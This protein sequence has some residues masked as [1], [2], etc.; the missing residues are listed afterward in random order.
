M[1]KRFENKKIV[2]GMATI[3]LIFAIIIVSSF[4]P[5]ILDPK[6]IMTEE[7]LTDELI[8]SAIVLSV[9]IA[10]LTIAQAANA[11]NPNSEIAKSKVEFKGSLD[12]IPNHSILFQWIKRVLQ[13]RDKKEIAEREMAKLLIPL[14]IYNLEEADILTL[15]TPQ[16]INGKY[17][18]PYDIERLRAVIK[19]KKKIGKI[20]FV[21]PNYYTSVKSIDSDK[22][23][24]ELAKSENIKKIMSIIIDLSTRIIMT[25][26]FASILGSLVRDLTQDGGNTAQAWMR[27]LSRMFAFGQSC[28]LGYT[29]GCKLNDL[30][31]FYILKRVEIHT[32]FLEDKNFIYIDESK[33]LYLLEHKEEEYDQRKE[34]IYN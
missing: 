31:A 19:L 18:G 3:G 27:F 1:K 16:S 4:W 33:E 6:R 13:P 12:K 34:D 23:L 7:F 25:W 5:F 32:L 22:T 24:S 10:A 30:D 14:E 9:T 21:S 26:V 11:Q 20:R 28:F 15:T 8:I 2:F 29:M 17:Y